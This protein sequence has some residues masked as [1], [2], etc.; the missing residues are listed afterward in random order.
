MTPA[1]HLTDALLAIVRREVA[2]ALAPVTRQL[3]SVDATQVELG[4]EMADL[5]TALKTVLKAGAKVADTD[6]A[7]HQWATWE[8]GRLDKEVDRL[9]ERIDDLH[10]DAFQAA[11]AAVKIPPRRVPWWRRLIGG[12]QTRTPK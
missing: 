8:V 12:P 3:D 1:D 5:R 9:D 6:E 4:Q 2:A 10:V 11:L 7:H